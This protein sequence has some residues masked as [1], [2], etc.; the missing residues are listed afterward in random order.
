M[1]GSPSWPEPTPTPEPPPAT[2]PVRRLHPAA[3]AVYSASAAGNLAL[4]LAVVLGMSVLGNGL[5]LMDLMRTLGYGVVGLVVAVIIGYV[6]WSTTRYWISAAGISHH[7]GLVSQKDTNVPFDRIQALDVQQ[8]VLQRWFGVQRVD[9]Q[10]GA[11]G[12]GGEISLPALLPDAVA[13]LRGLKP[14]AVAEEADGVSRALTRRELVEAAFTAGQLGIVLPVLAVIGQAAGQ[15]AEEEGSRNAVQLI[16]DTAGGW[17]LIGVALLVLAWVLSTLG[18]FIAFAGFTV[19]RGEDRLRIR[20]G[21]L[22][23][24]EA[25]VPLHRVRAVRVV[26]GVFR[27]PFGLCALSIEVTGYAE[28]A[29]AA[30]TLF[31]L[32][33]VG[34]VQEFLD[35]FLPE[36]AAV[37]HGERPEGAVPARDRRTRSAGAVVALDRPPARAARR[38]IA[39]PVLG[40]LVLVVA[41]WFFVGP[42]A[43]LALLF[44]PYGWARWRAAGWRF[45]DG[46]LAVRTLRIARTTV[47]AP[48]RYRE[49]HTW[50][51]NVFQRRAHLADLEVAFGKRT[52]A[53]IRHLDA[54]TAQAAWQAL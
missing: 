4:P 54:A 36:M 15:V 24:S 52:T 38:Y 26:E 19:T 25:T 11:G 13:E 18:A 39:P 16:P 45:E 46:R 32:V 42:W 31:P 53:R 5:D 35:E 41:G 29:S 7:T 8:G 44:A 1:T 3:I 20:R 10:T 23:R 30:R 28:E 27:R 33:R 34:E 50:A 49:S 14:S 6:R 2:A 22:Q 9:V 48:A 51:Q 21:L 40:A 12:K 17:V 47:L 43:L 37:G